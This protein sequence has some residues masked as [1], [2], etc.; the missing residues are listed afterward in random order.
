MN[1]ADEGITIRT[2]TPMDLEPMRWVVY[3][4]YYEILLDLYGADT[5][6]HYE[7]RSPDFMAMYLRRDPEGNFVAESDTG[8]IAGGLFCFV[9]GEVGWFGS[10]AVAPEWQGHKIGQRLT[11]RAID[12]LR[13]RG[14]TRIG[15]ETWP[16]APL[17]RHLYTKLGFRPGRMTVKLSRAAAAR[18]PQPGWSRW[19][20]QWVRVGDVAGLRTALEA[21]EQI[22]QAVWLAGEGIDPRLDYRKEVRVSV[23]SGWAELVV[24]Y[25]GR[26]L[27]I[28]FALCYVKKPSGKPVHALDV[29]LL[30]VSPPTRDS[31]DDS[32]LVAML[33]AFDR[34]ALQLGCQA[35]TCDVHASNERADAL[36]RELRFRPIYELIRME[37]PIPG[38]APE[39]NDLIHC[40]RWAG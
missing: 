18:P 20:V 16:E 10:L 31:R 29:R 33:A 5:A 39:R 13:D 8:T 34:R 38:R 14:C 27:P 7:L 32:P 40:A 36:L 26:G 15:L 2:M 23:A 35:V 11:Q 6:S 22:T 4:A 21:V 19:E 30:L 1:S 12:Y 17:T 24:L 28:A 9:W 25:D 37:L 3:R